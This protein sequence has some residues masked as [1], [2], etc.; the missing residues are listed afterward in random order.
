MGWLTDTFTAIRPAPPRNLLEWTGVAPWVSGK[1]QLLPAKYETYAREGYQANELVFACIN[2]LATSAAEP[3][4]HIRKP[5]SD[6]WVSR[7]QLLNLMDRPNPFMDRFEF[8]AT[9]IMHRALAGNAYALK[10]R[11]QS[12]KVVQ[13]W[14]LRPDRVRIVPDENRFIRRYEYTTSSPDPIILPVEDVIHFKT[15]NPLDDF[16]GMPPL[17]V[18]AGRVDVDNFMRDFVKA[19]FEN[20]GVPGG[21]LVTKNKMTADKIAEIRS[22]FKHTYGSAG[23]HDLMILDQ[24]EASFTPMT[25]AMGPQGL[26]VPELN[27]IS[28]SRITMAFGVPL[29]LIGALSG[30]GNS[31]YGN[32]KSERESFWNETLKPLYRELVGPLNRGLV[33]DF[34][35]VEEIAFDLSSVGALQPDLDT[36]HA[37]I[38]SDF[39][40]GYITRQEA[41][42]AIGREPDATDGVFLVPSNLTPVPVEDSNEPLALPPAPSPNGTKPVPVGGR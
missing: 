23:W 10:V 28:E 41:R 8:W 26:V 16:Y 9:V 35:G 20:A 18:I 38:R 15:R 22:R 5:G 25:S 13:L 24:T 33:P 29:T 31:S 14:L 3:V 11:S 36:L 27:E 2:M 7:H 37:R 6:Q 39:M 42:T 19:Y 30:A 1:A 32:K 21:M 4:M 40:A 34:F 17:M 12:G